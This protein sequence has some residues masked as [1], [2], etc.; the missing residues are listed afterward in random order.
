MSYC[1]WSSGD[2][3]CDVYCYEAEDGFMVEVARARYVFKEPLPAP[4]SHE[5]D[6][7]DA[8]F[9]R[10]KVVQAMVGRATTVTIG[11]PHDGESLSFDTPGECALELNRL[12]ACGYRVPQYAIDVLYEEQAELRSGGLK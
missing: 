11:L 6:G 4:V 8:F 7:H 12:R 5:K 1:R 10:H 3:Q 2:Y 9:A